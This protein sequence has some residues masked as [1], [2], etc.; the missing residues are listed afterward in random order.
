MSPLELVG[1]F[2]AIAKELR[3]SRPVASA[4]L[5]ERVAALGPAEPREPRWTFR[6]PSTRLVLGLAAAALLASLVAAG[7]TRTP[8]TSGNS[9]PLA[10]P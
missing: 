3:A 8:G 2:D 6:R 7:L 1:D 5:R 10:R 4:A 9:R